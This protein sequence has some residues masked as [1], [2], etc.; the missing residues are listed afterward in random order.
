MPI[1]ADALEDAGCVDDAVLAHCRRWPGP[2]ACGCWVI[3]LLLGKDTGT[4]AS[5]RP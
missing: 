4:P 1:L 3:D 5:A 2:H